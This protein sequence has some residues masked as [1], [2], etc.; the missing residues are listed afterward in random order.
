M[1]P[2]M[3]VAARDIR[4]FFGTTWG[5]GVLTCTL[6]V[7]GTWF[8]AWGLGSQPAYSAE[9]LERFFE[10]HGAILLAFSLL[11][12]IRAFADERVAGTWPLLRGSPLSDREITMGKYFA[13]MATLGVQSALSAYLPALILVHGRV[14]EMQVL[15]GYAGALG[16]ASVG[17]AV[18][19]WASSHTKRQ[20]FAAVLTTAVLVPLV[21]ASRFSTVVDPPF[22]DVWAYASLVERHQ[23]AW[24]AGQANTET[25]ALYGTL[26]FVFLLMATQSLCARRWA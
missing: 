2:M 13:V 11:L 25:I 17:T 26:T 9:V 24:S 14:G 1:T 5:V 18:G 4:G 15:V 12:S 21:A 7:E 20:V 3:L 23:R 8:L 16:L 6:V 19:L 10:I 22:R